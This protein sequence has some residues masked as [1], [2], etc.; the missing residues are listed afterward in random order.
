[1][2]IQGGISPLSAIYLQ[3]M[4]PITKTGAIQRHHNDL[5]KE[6]EFSKKSDSQIG[7][8]RAIDFARRISRDDKG[9]AW[10]GGLEALT[11]SATPP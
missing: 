8:G 7:H 10:T 2:G 1:M 5:H 11:R 3:T 9:N 4:W 6:K